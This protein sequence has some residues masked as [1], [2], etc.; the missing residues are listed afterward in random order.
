MLIEHVTIPADRYN[1]VLNV[2]Q[3]LRW[4]I[5]VI[6]VRSVI[7]VSLFIL[8]TPL[9]RFSLNSPGMYNLNSLT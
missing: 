5:I 6:C 7:D 8:T 1:P 3:K 4:S 2:L 9:L